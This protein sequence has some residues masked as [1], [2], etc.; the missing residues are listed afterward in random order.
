MLKDLSSRNDPAF[1]CVFTEASSPL[2][3]AVLPEQVL[4]KVEVRP[5]S[6]ARLEQ[7]DSVVIV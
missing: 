7:Q 5:S 2:L 3:S 1:T 4:F 6:L